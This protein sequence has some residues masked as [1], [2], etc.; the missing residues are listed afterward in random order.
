MQ[1]KDCQ[2]FWH[3]L[4]AV[5]AIVVTRVWTDSNK[6]RFVCPWRFR[7]FQSIEKSA[8][9]N[10]S[11]SEL[12]LAIGS[13][14]CFNASSVQFSPTELY[15]PLLVG[16]DKKVFGANSTSIWRSM[17][18][19]CWIPKGDWTIPRSVCWQLSSCSIALTINKS[20]PGSSER[21]RTT[22]CTAGTA[23]RMT[24]ALCTSSS[25]AQGG[26]RSGRS[27]SRVPAVS[28]R[29]IRSGRTDSQT[30]TLSAPRLQQLAATSIHIALHLLVRHCRPPVSE[31]VIKFL[32]SFS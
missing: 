32:F 12:M 18:S 8:L 13:L 10:L 6:F 28:D 29:R 20:R 26:L 4:R 1:R 2:K 22:S 14:S 25:T 30:S 7:L 3:S 15:A 19:K 24:M 11:S 9:F 16:G 27:T 31:P 23:T 17:R 5:Y 21:S